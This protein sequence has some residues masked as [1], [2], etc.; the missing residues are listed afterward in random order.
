MDFD[1][2]AAERLMNQHVED[3]RREMAMHRLG[4]QMKEGRHS[5]WRWLV[6]ELGYRLVALG[7][8]LEQHSRPQSPPLEA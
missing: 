4:R 2:Y 8:W 1:L 7:A 5:Q 6:C 3:T